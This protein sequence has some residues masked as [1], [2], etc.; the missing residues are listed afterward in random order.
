MSANQFEQINRAKKV[1]ALV[2]Y[3]DEFMGVCGLG[4]DPQKDAT[5]MVMTLE[6]M[7]DHIWEHHAVVGCGQPKTP[8]AE[9]RREVIA[10][11]QGRVVPYE[12]S[13][14]EPQTRRAGASR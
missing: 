9:T 5:A 3:F 6:S 10:A 1:A 12:A 13:E 4:L 14:D 8:S 2:A 7:K 11:Y